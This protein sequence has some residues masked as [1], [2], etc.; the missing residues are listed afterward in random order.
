MSTTK[1][2]HRPSEALAAL[3]GLGMRVAVCVPD[4]WLGGIMEQVDHD[5]EMTLIRATHEEEA[6]AIACGTR[7]GGA[8][9]VMLIQNVGLLTMGAGMVSLAQRYQ[10]PLLILASYRGSTRDPLFYHVPK[11]RATEPVLQG[12]GVRYALADPADP[13]GP[14]VER[15]AAFAEE[16]SSAFAEESSSPF[17]LLLSREDIYW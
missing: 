10:F 15:G 12:L 4:S 9:T 13:I 1:Q 2:S 17:V 16:S 14:Q 3:K 5:P 11:G 8:R 7:L 6:L